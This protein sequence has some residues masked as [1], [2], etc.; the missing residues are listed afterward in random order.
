MR[1]PISP[2]DRKDPPETLDVKGIQGLYVSAVCGPC[3]TPIQ[4]SGN[5]D[6]PVDE[7]LGM[8]AEMVV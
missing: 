8:E 6:C 2:G 5:T 3:L 1:N 7:N 4:E